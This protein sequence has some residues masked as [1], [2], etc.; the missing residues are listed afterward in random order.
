M[1]NEDYIITQIST[2]EYDV[3]KEGMEEPYHNATVPTGSSDYP[4][5]ANVNTLKW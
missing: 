2:H 4:L 3:W 1:N 5:D